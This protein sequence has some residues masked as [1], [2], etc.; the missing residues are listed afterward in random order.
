MEEA[1]RLKRL[2]PYLFTIIDNLKK[3]VAA[4]GMDIIDLAMG[5]PDLAP[6]QHII[7][8]LTK[9][10]SVEGN[11]R[12]SK[13]DGPIERQLNIAISDWYK[14]KF[15]VDLDP[16]TEVLPLIGS[17]EGVAHLS[18]GF[19]N[20]DDIALI[21]SPAYPVH[22]NGVIMAGGILFNLPLYKENNYLPDLEDIQSDV[23]RRSKLFL[24]SYPHNP[25][26]AVAN[27]DFYEKV[28]HWGKGKNLILAH[29]AAYSDFVF[30]G[31]K[32]SSL[33]QFKGAKEN[34]GIEFHTLSKSY[35]MA[36]WRIGF[37]VGNSKILDVLKKTKSYIDFGIFRGIQQAA[38][39]ALSGPQDCVKKTVKTYK[40][41]VDVFVDGLNKIN[42]NVPKPKATFYVWA[43]IP[44]KYSGLTSLEFSS[45]MLRETGVASAPGTGFGEYGEGY[46]RFALVDS[47]ERLQEAVDRIKPFL[48]IKV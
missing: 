2:P 9:S 38:I 21:P 27:P 23:L 22:F 34:F 4:T 31:H 14:D 10:C 44:M 24:F 1:N 13:A 40:E 35:S 30:E 33:L 8:E 47:I 26:G 39:K 7:D 46:I 32:A 42:W 16:K 20:P 15:N 12:Y 25:T 11:H 18:T 48:E 45:L 5:N 19:L 41:R 28:V 6:A 3:E 43:H 37:V 17:K 29:D 36:G